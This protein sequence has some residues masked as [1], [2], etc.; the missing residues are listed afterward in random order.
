MF[1]RCK[2]GQIHAGDMVK[3]IPTG[4]K[5]IVAGVN[6]KEGRIVR[7]GYP[8]PSLAPLA[9]CELVES[10]SVMVTEHIKESLRKNGLSSYVEDTADTKQGEGA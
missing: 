6:R 1:M 5:W 9:E 8:F 4:E 10:D 2:D 7:M 3:H